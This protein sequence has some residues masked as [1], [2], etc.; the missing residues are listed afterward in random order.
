MSIQ[1]VAWCALAWCVVRLLRHAALGRSYRRRGEFAP[2]WFVRSVA[3]V[4]TVACL[5]GAFLI[6]V[7]R[8]LA[9]T[10]FVIAVGLLAFEITR[11]VPT[12]SPR[13]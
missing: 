1:V 2:D 3:G 7:S 5:L 8:P 11:G 13:S 12:R 6:G 9:L 10:G 4:A